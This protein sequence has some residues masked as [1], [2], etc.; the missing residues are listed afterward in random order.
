MTVP[1]L[2]GTNGI[3][4]VAGRDIDVEFAY[5]VGS[6][7]AALF[8]RK[9]VVVGRDGRVSSRMLCEALVGGL[10]GQGAQVED[11]GLISTPALQFLVKNTGASG[12]V[13]VTASHNPPEYNGFKVIDCDGIEITREKEEKVETLVERN[14]WRAGRFS[15]G[16]TMPKD[17]LQLYLARLEGH[18]EEE[19]GKLRGIKVVVDPGNGVSALT[20]PVLL[21]RLGCEVL[22]VNDNIDGGFPGRPSEPRPENLATLSRVVRQAKADLGVAHDGDGDRAIFADE[23][24]AVHW[25]DRTLALVVDEVLKE[26]P[27]GKVVTPVN[28]SMALEEIVSKRRGKLILTRVG[29]IFV[30]R[31]MVETGAVLGGE[32]NGGIFY[33]PHHSVRDGTMAT[34]LVLKA[35]ARNSLPLSGLLDR[36][37]K[38]VMAK[39]KFQCRSEAAKRRA[40]ARLRGKLKGRVSS[41]LDGLRV[42]VKGRGWVLVR[43]SGTEP[44]LRF[45]AEGL[46]EEDLSWLMDEFRPLVLS[47][48]KEW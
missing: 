18:M 15:G 25:G 45:Y 43:P 36:L 47:A 1:R 17:P 46:T 3:R 11:C 12:G 28:S 38:L 42:D 32:E 6:S 41:E 37:P 34:L 19:R 9:R 7:V 26:R 20:T 13:M 33:A 2:F 14:S 10:L 35:V 24:G 48:L 21:R 30:S 8:R 40:M 5:G 23:T 27:G 44:L 16:R 39:E 31:T 4:G 22:T 29:S